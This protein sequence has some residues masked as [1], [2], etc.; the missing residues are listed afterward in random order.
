MTPDAPKRG[1]RARAAAAEIPAEPPSAAAAAR[2]PR[3]ERGQ[4][5]VDAILD[6]AAALLV[7]E[8]AA[9]VTMHRVARRSCT[10]TG[11][12]YHFF[13]DRET[14]LR[15]LGERHACGLRAVTTRIEQ[16]TAGQWARLSTAEAVDR[17]LGPFLTYIDEHPDLPAVSRLARASGWAHERDAELDR[18]VIR[19]AEDVVAS[20]CPDATPAETTSRALAMTAM[21]EGVVGASARP[22][23]A[24]HAALSP[25]ILRQELRRALVAYLDSYSARPRTT[26][27]SRPTE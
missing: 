17:F 6:A 4:R 10:T 19:L 14:L 26:G 27:R 22:T 24:A 13:P 25:A 1:Q 9:G 7:E 2:A 8:G 21:V 15:A 11:S 23:D 18:Q 5:R 16:E 3:Q 20:R 12:M